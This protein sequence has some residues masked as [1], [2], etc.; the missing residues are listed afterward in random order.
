MVCPQSLVHTE[1]MQGNIQTRGT[2]NIQNNDR[3]KT[4]WPGDQDKQVILVQS[5]MIHSPRLD[6]KHAWRDLHCE[7]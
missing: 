1:Q 7:K 2:L 6:K 5:K 4:R 3:G